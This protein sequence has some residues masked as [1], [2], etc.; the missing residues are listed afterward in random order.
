MH[1]ICLTLVLIAAH[2]GSALAQQTD[3]G[4]VDLIDL[5]FGKKKM[6]QTRKYREGKKVHFSVFP[7][8]VNVPGGGR[9][10]IT[11]AN[12]AFYL[13]DPSVTNLS[14]VY[15]I[16]CTN[17]GDRYGLYV[18]PNLWLP[19][20][21][22]NFIGDY[23]IAHF[24]QYTWGVGGDSPAWDKSLVDYDYIRLYQNAL[25]QISGFWYMGPGYAFDYHYNIIE[26][27]YTESG[28]LERYDETPHPSTISS[29]FT[30]NV[31]YDARKNAINPLGGAYLL[32]SWRWNATG[33]G[34]TFTN[35]TLFIDGRKYMP[36]SK[37]RTSILALRSY[38]W[39]VISGETPYLDLPAT[40][41]APATGVASRGFE[42]GRYRSTATLY[43]EAEHRYQISANGLW[44][45]VVFANASSA[46]E[47]DTQNF[48]YWKPG[49]G[50]G[51]RV[52]LNKFSD[53]NLSLDVAFSKDYWGVWLNIGEMF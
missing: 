12:A 18:R 35:N 3:T 45:I 39:T 15:L 13:G 50:A 11:A 28:H 47:F 20:N 32:V 23:R 41:W 6:D 19:K 4:R 29:G 52:K 30:A 44:G 33:L 31:L 1:R 43:A 42:A 24:P 51:L 7:A 53:T 38:Y 25:K 27:E 36:L 10:V 34:S 40:S 49:G 16:P 14:N 46:S 22:F 26:S 5:L 8:A 9:A 21:T 17:L 2:V 48:K 37:S